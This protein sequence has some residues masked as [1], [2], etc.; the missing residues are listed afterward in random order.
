MLSVI[1]PTYNEAENIRKVIPKITNA[2]KGIP[3]EIILVDDDSPDE[4]WK[5]AYEFNVR[6][7]RRRGVRGLASAVVEGFGMAK[8]E[9]FIVMDAD[10]QHDPALLP[11]LYAA[12]NGNFPSPGGRGSGR[13]AQRNV[14]LSIASRYV[15]GGSTSDWRGY[16]LLGS[17]LT[18]FIARFLCPR[19]VT[20]PLSGY[21]AVDR[22]M[23]ESIRASLKPEGFKI[24]LE[25]LAN[26]PSDTR[27]AEV[28]LQFGL[29]A[30]GVSKLSF[31]VQLQF[32][33]QVL[34][35]LVSTARGQFR[36]FSTILFLIGIVILSHLWSL[37]LLY[38]DGDLRVRIQKHIEE[39]AEEQGW[40]LSDVSLNNVT[41][42]SVR[43]LHRSHVR[44]PD[45]KECF[46]IP[47][48]S[49]VM[50]PCNDS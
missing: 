6:V 36:L 50:K 24:L 1:L 33:T 14:S 47:L 45:P 17:R 41:R 38:L 43:I 34:R 31:S 49:F 42:E 37:R 48:D 39:V 46:V 10:G 13:G 5:V 16:R 12:V 30:H 2:L 22:S 29:R 7:K 20:D 4:T 8:G 19:G 28:P 21:F 40:L 11:K 27:I 3:H 25:I 18:T 32:C 15:R 26:L 23:F 9:I 44:G 35:L